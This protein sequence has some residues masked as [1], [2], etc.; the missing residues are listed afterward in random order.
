MLK[1]H[2]KVLPAI[3]ENYKKA[4]KYVD[5]EQN[6]VDYITKVFTENGILI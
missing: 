2:M 6:I 1:K 4:L 5:Y 3:E